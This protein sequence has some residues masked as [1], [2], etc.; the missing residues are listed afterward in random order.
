MA[1]WEE[2]V[3]EIKHLIIGELVK[4][5]M[6][7]CHFSQHI[8]QFWPGN[9]FN[10]FCSLLLVCKEIH[11][12]AI[13]A[14]YIH[15]KGVES[16]C[17]FQIKQREMVSA[18]VG[19]AQHRWHGFSTRGFDHHMIENLLGRYIRNPLIYNNH[20]LLQ[21]LFSCFHPNVT[22]RLLVQI[23][24]FLEANAESDPDMADQQIELEFKHYSHVW[25]RAQLKGSRTIDF[26]DFNVTKI[27]SIK[28]QGVENEVT[29]EELHALQ[30]K[31]RDGWLVNMLGSVD[32]SVSEEI[33]CY[34]I[35]PNRLLV[36]EIWQDDAF[37]HE[38]REAIGNS[39]RET[40]S[41]LILEEDVWNQ[42]D[43]YRNA[44]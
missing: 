6:R 19:Y 30:E 2:L 15:I 17:F 20:E 8:C 28:L 10:E 29:G 37:C 5:L 42:V 39:I 12:L 13:Q 38:G 34:I 26:H 16:G 27:D 35:N 4:Q 22:V 40:Y 1:Q 25:A 33:L 14:S 44:L 9:C 31:L 32:N 24:E 21:R 41:S 11:Y 18:L 3:Y 36:Q 7:D 43:E 23:P